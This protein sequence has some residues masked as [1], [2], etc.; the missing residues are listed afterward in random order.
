MIYIVCVYVLGALISV[1][2]RRDAIARQAVQCGVPARSTESR[3]MHVAAAAT[4]PAFPFRFFLREE[5]E[6]K[7]SPEI[8]IAVDSDRP[9]HAVPDLSH[10]Q[11]RQ[12][13]SLT[14]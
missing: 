4:W 12:A 11:T 2:A 8:E 9:E 5:D 6:A 3:L 13:V 1:L 7:V 10:F 14:K